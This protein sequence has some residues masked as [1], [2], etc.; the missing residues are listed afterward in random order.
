MEE[1]ET[2]EYAL[3]R[4][5]R[6]EIGVDIADGDMSPAGFASYAYPERHVILLLYLIRNWKG[7]P[8]A[9]DHQALQW[10]RTEDLP[11]FAVL[12]A[13]RPLIAHLMCYLEGDEA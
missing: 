2:P 1:G 3:A 12:P 6:E 9:L 7:T 13:D 8:Q 10:V 11:G 5:L 4:E